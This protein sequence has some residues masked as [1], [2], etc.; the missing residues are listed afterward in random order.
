MKDKKTPSSLG[1]TVILFFCFTLLLPFQ[2]R[3]AIRAADMQ[4]TYKNLEIFSNVLSMIEQNYVEEIDTQE[5][6]E[7]AIKGMLTSLDP[8]SSY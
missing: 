1:A 7:G 8:H 5:I 3:G 2:N 6:I 4:E